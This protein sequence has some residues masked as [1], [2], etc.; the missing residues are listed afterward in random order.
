MY[1]PEFSNNIVYKMCSEF[2]TLGEFKIF[3]IILDKNFSEEDP[4]IPYSFFMETCHTDKTVIRRAI[5]K[6]I[7][8]GYIT[9]EPVLNS[10]RYR[11]TEKVLKMIKK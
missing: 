4:I 7:E 11:L 3:L 8:K 6:L 2:A 5:D 10:F 1:P 9:K